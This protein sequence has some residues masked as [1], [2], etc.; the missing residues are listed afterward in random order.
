MQVRQSIFN[1]VGGPVKLVH[2]HFSGRID[3]ASS[4]HNCEGPV[5]LVQSSFCAMQERSR[6][7]FPPMRSWHLNCPALASQCLHSGENCFLDLS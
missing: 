3:L 6:K 4:A 5:K 2:V 1:M 7:Q